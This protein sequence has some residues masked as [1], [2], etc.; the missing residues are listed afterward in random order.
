MCRFTKIV[1]IFTTLSSHSWEIL[2]ACP[3]TDEQPQEQRYPPYRVSVVY[4]STYRWCKRILWILSVQL[5]T[6]PLIFFDFKLPRDFERARPTAHV[7]DSLLSSFDGLDVQSGT[8][9]RLEGEAQRRA[10]R[11]RTHASKKVWSR[12]TDGVPQDHSGL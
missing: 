1:F 9:A 4:L 7:C 6:S 3:M 12:S 2:V 8:P 11:G 5:E 10:S